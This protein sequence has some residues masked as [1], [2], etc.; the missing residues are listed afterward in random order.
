MLKV[1]SGARPSKPSATTEIGFTDDVWDVIERGWAVEP[2]S[3]PLLS[4]FLDSMR[5]A[6]APTHISRL[7]HK[8]ALATGQV[9]LPAVV[10][11]TTS[12]RGPAVPSE[13]HYSTYTCRRRALCVSR[14]SRSKRWLEADRRADRDQLYRDAACAA[15]VRE[16]RAKR[17]QPPVACVVRRGAALSSSLS[18]L[19]VSAG[20]HNFTDGEIMLLTDDADDPRA[21]PT[22]KNMLDA[23]RW[24]VRDASPDSSLFLHCTSLCARPSQQGC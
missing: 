21:H 18:V 12:T 10:G 3:R 9:Q 24:L 23:M 5:S 14:T 20:Y 15:G 17:P 22:R 13:F 19:P 1:L 11:S 8:P 7:A 16:G 6:H 2:S 4:E